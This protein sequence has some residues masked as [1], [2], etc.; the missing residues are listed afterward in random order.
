[1]CTCTKLYRE[2]RIGKS[3]S[4]SIELYLF[5]DIKYI[6]VIFCTDVNDNKSS[7]F[8]LIFKTK[9][10]GNKAYIMCVGRGALSLNF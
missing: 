7:P 3:G 5:C 4:E 10:K 9:K 6:R 1:M 2:R 8:K